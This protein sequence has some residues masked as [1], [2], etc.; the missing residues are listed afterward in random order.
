[1]DIAAPGAKKK[2][3]PIHYSQFTIPHS[4][5]P[6]PCSLSSVPCSLFPVPCSLF[7]PLFALKIEF[8]L[9]SFFAQKNAKCCVFNKSLGSFPLF[10]IF[11]ALSCRLALPAGRFR[12]S[13]P[14]FLP[15]LFIGQP[16]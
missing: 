15:A 1:M 11:F 7:S 14:R 3:Q 8:V 5:F 13:F 2:N 16:A 9:S 6:V 12:I 4:L 10:N